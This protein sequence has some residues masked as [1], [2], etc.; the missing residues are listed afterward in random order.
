MQKNR[1]KSLWSV[2]FSTMALVLIPVSIGINY[3]GKLFAQALKLPLWLDSIGTILAGILAGPWIGAISG[4][5]NN[6]IFGLT[7][8]PISFAYALTSIAIGIAAGLMA[9]MGFARDIKSA[10]IMGL[11]IAGV[12]TIVSTPINIY[13]WGGQTGNI[14]G[15]ALFGFLRSRN[16]PLWLASGLD[17]FVVDLP[18]K[19]VTTII[20]FIIFTGLP[21]RITVLFND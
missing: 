12:A 13:F 1:R 10:F 5:I 16:W 2:D 4:A 11:V 14:W 8:D 20:A 17:E 18:D 3:V 19:I 6:I 21:K 9:R 15:D 7:A